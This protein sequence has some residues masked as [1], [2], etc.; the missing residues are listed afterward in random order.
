MRSHDIIAYLKTLKHDLKSEGIVSVGL[1]GSCAKDT[2]TK[3][4]DID[5]VYKTT[6]KFIHKHKGW[7][8]FTYLNTN[9]R[10]KV[11]MKFKSHTDM[12]DINSDSALKDKIMSQAIYA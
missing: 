2:Q 11:S 10:D 12:F 6:D 1:F 7:T 9:L 5:I 8:A 3:H 4:S